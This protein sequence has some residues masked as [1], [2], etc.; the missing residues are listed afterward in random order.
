LP[1]GSPFQRRQRVLSIARGHHEK[2]Q[3][4]PQALPPLFILLFPLT[5]LHAIEKSILQIDTGG[6]KAKIR[7]VIFTND[8]RY[9]VPA[10][11]DKTVRFWDVESG[12]TVRVLS[13]QIFS[14]MGVIGFLHIWFLPIVKREWRCP[15]F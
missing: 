3:N 8:G 5:L 2:N 1:R 7:D 11:D 15:H 13:I 4:L 14:E 6:H 10:S 9:L 12:E